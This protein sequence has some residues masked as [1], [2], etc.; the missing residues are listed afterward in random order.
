MKAF[1]VALQNRPKTVQTIAAEVGITEN[2]ARIWLDLFRTH[3]PGQP[4]YVRIADW[5]RSGCIWVA[6]YMWG[7]EADELKP[8]PMVPAEYHRRYRRKKAKQAEQSNERKVIH[9]IR[10]S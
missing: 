9:D 3:I 1:V 5:K 2:T 6:M 7:I 10:I 4:V 8:P